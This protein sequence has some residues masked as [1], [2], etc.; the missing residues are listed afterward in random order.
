MQTIRAEA[1]GPRSTA[2][3]LAIDDQPEGPLV[4]VDESL[5]IRVVERDL[6]A[7]RVG[8]GAAAVISRMVVSVHEGESVEL[9]AEVPSD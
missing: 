8:R 4:V 7:K 9:S 3:W 5:G 2:Y 1:I 6:L